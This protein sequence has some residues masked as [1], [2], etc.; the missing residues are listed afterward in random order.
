MKQSIHDN[1]LDMLAAMPAGAAQD[2]KWPEVSKLYSVVLIRLQDCE[3][4]AAV[5]W[6]VTHESWRPAPARLFEIA[7]ELASPIPDCEQAYVEIVSGAQ[8]GV[9]CRPH[10]E[11][12][13]IKLAG[14]PDFSHPIIA[15]IVKYCGGWEMICSGAANLSEGLKKQIRGAHESVSRQW[16]EEV[17]AQLVRPIEGRDR[18]YFPVYQPIALLPEAPREIEMALEILLIRKGVEA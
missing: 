18:R 12:P 14:P 8:Q 5:E 11:R 13:S 4:T 15:Q 1:L 9:Y 17:K 7:A 3:A 2:A 10:P 16:M 6:A